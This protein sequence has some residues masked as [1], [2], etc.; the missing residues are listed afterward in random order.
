MLTMSVR[1][2]GLN[3]LAIH[4]SAIA[5]LGALAWLL[6]LSAETVGTAIVVI[7]VVGVVAWAVFGSLWWMIG[8]FVRRTLARDTDPDESRDAR[9]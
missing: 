1:R 5:V 9:R 8:P 4:L 2:G 7:G 3:H 6:D